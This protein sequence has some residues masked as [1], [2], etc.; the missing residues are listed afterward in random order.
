M[1]PATG[2]F[3]LILAA[4]PAGGSARAWPGGYLGRLQ[5]LAVLQTLNAD[6]LGGDSAT[7]VLRRWCADHRLATPAVIKAIRVHGHDKPADQAVLALL[8]AKRDDIVAYRRVRLV[9]GRHVLSEADNWYL[10]GRLTAEMNHQ[11]ETT[12]TPF[13]VVVRPLGFRR[14]TLDVKR[15]FEPLP[16]GWEM[17]PGSRPSSGV[18]AVP[19]DVLSHRAVLTDRVGFPFSVVQ[20]TYTREVLA[21]PPPLTPPGR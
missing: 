10:P 4:A 3:A 13:G 16:D 17:A 15:L 6:L 1:K 20:E 18:L 9:C 14:R 12:D 7:E 8:A 21:F 2:L 19:Y 11:L 5:A